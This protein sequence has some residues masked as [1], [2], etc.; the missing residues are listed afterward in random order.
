MED[1]LGVDRSRVDHDAYLLHV[2]NV[3][4]RAR[5]IGIGEYVIEQDGEGER[6]SARY[7]R[8]VHHSPDIHVIAIVRGGEAYLALFGHELETF[9]G[10]VN[11]KVLER[12]GNMAEDGHIH[13]VELQ[14]T[15]EALLAIELTHLV[16]IDLRIIEI[17]ETSGE[18]R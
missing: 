8:L 12:A 5:Q 15:D 2:A 7:V 1:S 13:M 14:A 9:L 6:S 4:H 10:H 11:G 17:D 3:E 16:R 18:L